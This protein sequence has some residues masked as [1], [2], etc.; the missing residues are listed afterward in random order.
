MFLKQWQSSRI[1][2]LSL[3]K[4]FKSSTNLVQRLRKNGQNFD[5]LTGVLMHQARWMYQAL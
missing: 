2:N 3:I 4:T 1:K 5:P